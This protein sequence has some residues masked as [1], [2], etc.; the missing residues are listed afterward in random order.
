MG[1]TDTW[2]PPRPPRQIMTQAILVFFF[3]FDYVKM[4]HSLNV[5]CLSRVVIIV[6]LYQK[7]P[8]HH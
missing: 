5:F 3:L 2:R 7:T 4:Q 6:E 1:I 8:Y